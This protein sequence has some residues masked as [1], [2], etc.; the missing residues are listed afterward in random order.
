[1]GRRA[2]ISV[3]LGVLSLV[4][5]FAGIAGA[6]TVEGE[7]AT[8]SAEIPIL[9]AQ[10]E[11]QDA[12]LEGQIGEISAVGAVL[13]ET[14]ARVSVAK[15]RTTELGG[16]TR[17]L[18][19]ELEVR[20]ETYEAAKAGYEEKARAAYKG[21]D[22][23]G[24]SFFL[25]G[26]LGSTDSPAGLADPRVAEILLEGRES[27]EDYR[28]SERILGNTLRQIS[29][30]T[31]DYKEALREKRVRTRELRR[32]EAE[33]EDSIV[34][35][36][37]E[38][39]RAV[40]RLRGLRAAERARVLEQ[41]AATGVGETSRGHELKIAHQEIVAEPGE[42]ISKRAYERLYRASARKYGFGEDWYVLAAVGK[43]ES[44]HGE[45]MGPSSAGAM[46]PM[47]FLPS[48][49]ETAGVDG[50]GD[51]EANIMDP[52]DAIPAAAGYLRSGGAPR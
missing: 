10:V 13:E 34:R 32:R 43:V 26:L 11:E 9:E 15:K 5:G 17:T 51:G 50:N 45:N 29:Q 41:R 19:R 18:E 33:L 8:R 22:V 35:I 40:A 36:S 31:R 21:A 28:K 39:T 44:N 46:G 2:R 1:M 30:K 20:R 27:L 6:R 42:P 38:R 25:D 16:Q 48:T 37:S 24:L 12:M 3:I 7:S 49:W 14:Q 23:E 47:Q 4:V 52:R